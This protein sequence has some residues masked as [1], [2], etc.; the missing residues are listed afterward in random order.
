M[1]DRSP[2]QNTQELWVSYKRSNRIEGCWKKG[3]TK[4]ILKAI[5]MEN[6]PKLSDSEAKI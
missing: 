6:P 3:G 4:E 5:M 2:K 1:M